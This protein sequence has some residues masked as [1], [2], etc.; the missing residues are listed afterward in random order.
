MASKKQKVS[1][2]RRKAPYVAAGILWQFLNKLKFVATPTYLDAKELEEYGISKGWT[3]HL[4][5][6][7]KFLGL[8][9][10]NGTCTPALHSL[11]MTGDEY[12]HNLEEVVRR[13]YADLFLKIDPATD[14]RANIINFFIKHYSPA[15]A[16]SATTL[17]LDLCKEAGIPTAEEKP[18]KKDVGAKLSISRTTKKQVERPEGEKVG[19]TETP[20]SDD[21]LR[22]LYLKK[23]VDQVSPPDT[24]GK[25]AEAIKAEAE[26]RKA[27]LDRIEKLLEI[28]KDKGGR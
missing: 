5:S 15:S 19:L 9:E 6:T 16:E 7:L 27:E 11:Q 1:A 13:A 8:V 20:I 4:L 21:E 23:L 10:K 17:F 25:D 28:T 26:L 22:K 12:R 24:A 3:Y 2:G 18:A 14:S